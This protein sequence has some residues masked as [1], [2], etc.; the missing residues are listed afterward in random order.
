MDYRYSI[1]T[2]NPT[3]PDCPSHNSTNVKITIKL[4]YVLGEQ[5]CIKIVIF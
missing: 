4:F 3:Q 2:F 1:K 5:N